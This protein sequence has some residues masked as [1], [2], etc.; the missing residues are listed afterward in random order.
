MT[1]VYASVSTVAS[2]VAD[3][4]GLL[5]GIALPW[6]ADAIVCSLIFG[7]V[8]FHLLHCQ[9]QWRKQACPYREFPA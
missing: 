1:H 8:L 4:F 6:T 2:A 7:M 5:L 9:P 3:R